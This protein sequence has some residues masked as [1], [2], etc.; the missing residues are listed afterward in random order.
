MLLGRQN[1][2]SPLPQTSAAAIL[3]V[4]TQTPLARMAS[5]MSFPNLE[6]YLP[7]QVALSDW[8]D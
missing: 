3:S 8:L 7:L 5:Y 1:H 2:I 4:L 6:A